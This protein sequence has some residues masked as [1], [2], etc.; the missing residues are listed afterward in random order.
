MRGEYI[1]FDLETTG[2]NADRDEIIEI[3]A[4]RFRQGELVEMYQSFVNPGKPIPSEITHLT[5][6]DDDDV[7]D[8]PPMRALLPRLKTFFGDTTVVCHNA[9]FDLSFMQ[10][11]GLLA[12]NRALDTFDL[13]SVLLPSAP[14]YSLGALAGQMGV[15]LESAHRAYDDAEATGRLFWK[16]YEKLR[17]LPTALL[18]EIIG[19]ADGVTWSA[20]SVFQEALQDSLRSGNLT[21]PV[22]SPFDNLPL[23]I[24]SRLD[25]EEARREPLHPDSVT[26]SFGA[27]GKLAALHDSYEARPQQLDMAREVTGALNHGGQMLIEA[28][29][30]TGKSLA[31]LIP[32]ASWALQNG[33]RVTIATNTIN[34]QEQLLRKDIPLAREV[35][36]GDFR[37][38]VMKGRGN[39]LCPRR[40][41]TM[42]RRK[43]ANSDELREHWRKRWCG[44]MKAA[45]ATAAKS[46]CAAA[47]GEC[48]RA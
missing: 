7:A 43:P 48:G 21:A 3:G 26:R 46:A 14:R 23:N 37:A 13:A 35:V 41:A 25:M 11:H 19:F 24:E 5:G 44:C 10:K 27:D 32:A 16:L 6:I 8:A 42:R 1:A 45:R 20:T 18:T 38:A 33:N 31:Y 29:T 36:G 12:D 39:Y 4:A 47:N 9:D 22:K 28:G 15:P 30:G 34:L 2:L 17:L 40:L